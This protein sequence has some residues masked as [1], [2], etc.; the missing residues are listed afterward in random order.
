MN[1]SFSFNY[2]GS[3]ITAQSLGPNSIPDDTQVITACCV[4]V[5]SDDKIIAVDI[6][7]RGVDIPGGHID[8]G[9]S[10][11]EAMAR[12][13]YEEALVK[14]GTPILIDV[15]E[16]K[17]N[18]DKLGLKERPYMLI[19]AAKVTEMLD[20]VRNN[21]VSE[22]LILDTLGFEK[23]YFADKV[24]GKEMVTKALQTIQSF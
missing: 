1:A 23:L 22:R 16:V 12:E 2:F 10:A 7:G 3:V 20:F 17:S 14:V 8:P 13:V 18:D 5:I 15:L 11:L 21:E 24:Y 4:P 6:I 19:Y 9:E